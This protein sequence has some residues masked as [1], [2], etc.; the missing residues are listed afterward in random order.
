MGTYHYG[1]EGWSN[2]YRDSPNI[3]VAHKGSFLGIGAGTVLLVT[4]TGKFSYS[5]FDS[6]KF[7]P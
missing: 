7:R 4:A 3:Y 5:A 6:C 1:M 2:A